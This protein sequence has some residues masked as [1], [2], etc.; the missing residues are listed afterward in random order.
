MNI[1]IQHTINNNN[2]SRIKYFKRIPIQ[3]KDKPI[4]YNEII[5]VKSNLILPTKNKYTETNVRYSLPLR[6]LWIS[7]SCTK[8]SRKFS[9]FK[10]NIR[11]IM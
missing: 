11:N 10:A 4:L 3:A 6:R 9:H 2:T 7:L 1:F 5:F 8:I